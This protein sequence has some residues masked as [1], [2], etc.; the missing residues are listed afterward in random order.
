VIADTGTYT[1]LKTLS[2]FKGPWGV[3]TFPRAR[4]SIETP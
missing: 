3:V 2:G 1:V 4:G